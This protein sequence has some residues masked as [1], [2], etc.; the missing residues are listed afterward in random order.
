MQQ[1]GFSQF[2]SVDDQQL[3]ARV[4]NYLK[5][6]PEQI[7]G[8]SDEQPQVYL[9]RMKQRGVWADHIV[10]QALAKMLNLIIAILQSDGTQPIVMNNKVSVQGVIWLGYRS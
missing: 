8:F 10:V 3:R 1:L 6:H 9:Q 7:E 5:K 2:N 4:I